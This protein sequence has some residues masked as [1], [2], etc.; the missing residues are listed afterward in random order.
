MT[1]R[2]QRNIVEHT[3]RLL[4]D[5]N[6]S[7]GR[8]CYLSDNQIILITLNVIGEVLLPDWIQVQQVPTFVEKG[9]EYGEN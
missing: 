6:I 7:E 9:I 3:Y 8:I 4:T 1:V 2:Q 5:F